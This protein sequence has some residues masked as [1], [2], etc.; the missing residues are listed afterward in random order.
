MHTALLILAGLSFVAAQACFIAASLEW[1]EL[2][3]EVNERLPEGQKFEPMS[4]H[5]GTYLEFKRLRESVYPQSLRYKKARRL[6]IVGTLLFLFS[7][8]IAYSALNYGP[9][10]VILVFVFMMLGLIYFS[11]KWM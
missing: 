10:T 1:K 3:W 4:W 2:Q 6:G 5:I 7:V 8:T 11:Q 9:P